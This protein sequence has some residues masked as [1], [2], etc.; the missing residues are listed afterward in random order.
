MAGFVLTLLLLGK[1]FPKL[2]S[3]D[4]G[5]LVFSGVLGVALG[6]LLFLASLRRLGAGLNAIVST[7]YSPAVFLFAFLMFKETITTQ[8]YAG[9]VLVIA[10]ITIGSLKIPAQSDNKD[11][12]KG[13]VYGVGAAALTAYS[14]L[15]VRPIMESHSI[16]VVALVR[17]STGFI[18]SSLFLWISK[19]R[20]ALTDTMKTGLRNPYLV[21]GALLGTYLSVILWLSGY[22]YTLAGRAAIYNQLSTILIILMAAVFL[23]ESMTSR[24]WLAVALAICGALLVSSA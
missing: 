19:G 11:I 6:D 20:N 17:F 23:K 15:L 14:V 13:V 8:S 16:I 10:G 22:K 21:T 9:A 4:L 7:S 1:G 2:S 24:K 5:I 12:L 18:L 3:T